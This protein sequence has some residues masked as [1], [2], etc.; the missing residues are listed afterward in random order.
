MIDARVAEL[1]AYVKFFWE[2]MRAI[3]LV[4]EEVAAELGGED[5]LRSTFR[6]LLESSKADLTYLNQLLGTLDA[7]A[8]LQEPCEAELTKLRALSS[9]TPDNPRFA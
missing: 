2:E 1:Q 5:P 4:V 9:D 7:A 3:E 8:E 6:E